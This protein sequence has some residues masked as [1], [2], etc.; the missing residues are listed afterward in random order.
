[1]SYS[2]SWALKVDLFGSNPK[3]TTFKVYDLGQ[4]NESFCVSVSSSVK[5]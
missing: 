1:M 4:I 5:W 2:K 3:P